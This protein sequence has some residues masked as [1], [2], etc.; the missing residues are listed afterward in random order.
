[1]RISRVWGQG[2]DGLA[3]ISTLSHHAQ[4]QL[5]CTIGLHNQAAVLSRLT[6]CFTWAPM[7]RCMPDHAVSPKVWH[8]PTWT[9]GFS[10]HVAVP[11]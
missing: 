5:S 1:M 11:A 10:H 9:I 2:V 7:L 4:E 8:A 6:T 3:G